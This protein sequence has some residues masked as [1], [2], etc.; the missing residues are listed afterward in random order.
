MSTKTTKSFDCI[1]FKREAQRQIYEDTKHM[2][3]EEQ[4]EYFR[5]RAEEGS[6]GHWWR[7]VRESTGETS[8]PRSK[9]P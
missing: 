7:R 6:L 2:T 8:P 9:N 3:S 4:I 5:K 1:A